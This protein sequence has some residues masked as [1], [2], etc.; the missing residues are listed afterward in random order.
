MRGDLGF[1]LTVTDTQNPDPATNSAT[2]PVT[3]T[4]QRYA[5]PVA[6]AGSD[7]TVY[8][9]TAGVTLDASG[10]SQTDGHTLTYSW[11]QNSGIGVTLSDAIGLPADVHGALDRG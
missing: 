3:I 6:S 2:S 7:Q 8:V 1:T 10:S 4:V 9:G 11:V 5:S